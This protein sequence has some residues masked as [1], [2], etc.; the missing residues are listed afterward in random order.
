[1]AD[2]NTRI[3]PKCGMAVVDNY[4]YCKNCGVKLQGEITGAG[5]PI[6]CYCPAC[7]SE[8]RGNAR[9][10]RSCG[11]QLEQGIARG[12]YIWPVNRQMSQVDAVNVNNAV[13]V[14]APETRVRTKRYVFLRI[15]LVAVCALLLFRIWREGI[16]NYK[17]AVLEPSVFLTPVSGDEDAKE[18]QLKYDEIYASPHEMPGTGQTGEDSEWPDS[19][20]EQGG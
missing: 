20:N 12:Q 5:T 9:F 11:V 6:M 8:N 14:N 16:P 15:I 3:C 19:D 4:I 17:N 2:Q 7:G 1:M 18:L 10:C 13:N